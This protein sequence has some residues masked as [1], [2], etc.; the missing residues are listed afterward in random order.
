MLED[1]CIDTTE[2]AAISHSQCKRAGKGPE[3]YCR[4]EEQ[5]PDEVGH[6]AQKTQQGP[7]QPACHCANPECE[8]INFGGHQNSAV[9]QRGGSADT[10]RKCEGDGE[11]SSRN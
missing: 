6:G 5:C 4:H 7:G 10:Q 8:A 11:P 3:S 2:H 1:I 9:P